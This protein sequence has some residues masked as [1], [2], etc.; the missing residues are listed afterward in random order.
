MTEDQLEDFVSHLS[1]VV[2]FARAQAGQSPR[3]LR[4]LLAAR[5]K[6]PEQVRAARRRLLEDRCPDGSL[7]S[8]LPLQVIADYLPSWFGRSRLIQ[9]LP[10]LQVILLDEKRDLEVRWDESL[11]LLALAPWQIDALTGN[12]E[13]GGCCD[14][15]FADFLPRIMETRRVQARLEQRIGLLR[16]VES[17]R[18]YAAC[19]EGRLPGKLSELSLPL[20]SDPFTG[21]PFVYGAEAACAHL[22]GS[23]PRG[24]ELNPCFNVHYEVTILK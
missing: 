16:H 18:L 10:P 7:Q 11:K 9:S 14:G 5:V 8:L 23:P 6:D 12:S 1:G 22:R 20:P 2:G 17:L 21:K 24:E 19:H 13:P 3:S 4:A 15:L